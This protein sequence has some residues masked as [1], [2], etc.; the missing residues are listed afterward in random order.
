MK[1][2]LATNNQHK[3]K[4][5]KNI[6]EDP[7]LEIF[8][9]FDFPNFPNPE[10]TGETF[11]ENAI[12]K[13]RAAYQFTKMISVADDSGLEVDALDKAPG[14]LSARFA[15]EGCSFKDN[16]LKL[17]KLLKKV[18]TDKRTATFVCMV[19]VAFDL[20]KIKIVEGKVKGLITEVQM[21]VNG[22]GYDPLFYYPPFGKTFAQLSPDV[23]N[24]ISHRSVAFRKAKEVLLVG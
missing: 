19:A 13:A 24:Q 3:I 7:G 10:E 23:K 17:L 11:E 8:T 1:I 6:L 15:G 4:E 9:L 18:P 2:V 22:F 14:V 20:K 12:L 5:I 16:N 21:G